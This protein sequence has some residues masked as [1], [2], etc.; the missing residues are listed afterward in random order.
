MYRTLIVA[1]L[2]FYAGG[3]AARTSTSSSLERASPELAHRLA[4][5]I[6]SA[7][8]RLDVDAIARLVPEHD[9][10]V[11]VSN[12][13]PVKGSEYRDVMSRFYRSLKRLEWTWERWEAV[14]IS[15]DAVVFTGW[16]SAVA[17]PHEGSQL[18]ERSIHTMLFV[19]QSEGWK[20][21]ISHKTNLPDE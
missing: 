14:V 10:V 6:S 7:A 11:Y 16:A 12:G 17:T 9:Q 4:T 5:E 1:L 8:T 3:C 18:I 20:R 15:P 2:C 19:R 13:N 21:V